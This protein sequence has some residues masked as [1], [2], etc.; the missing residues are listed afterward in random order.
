MKRMYDLTVLVKSDFPADVP[1]KRELLVQSIIGSGAKVDEVTL[2]GK[3]PL[4]Y[5]IKKQKDAI[6]L[7]AHLTGVVKV[8]EIETAVKLRTDVLR[9]MLIVK[10]E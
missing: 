2:L 6:Y 8:N 4:A 7:M 5:P 10:E 1:S 3:K 9:Y